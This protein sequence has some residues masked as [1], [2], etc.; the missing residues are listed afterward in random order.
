LGPCPTQWLRRLAD[1]RVGEALAS[2]YRRAGGGFPPLRKEHRRLAR[3]PQITPAPNRGTR[4]PALSAENG[5]HAPR[6]AH[7]S[8]GKSSSLNSNAGR[9]PLRTLAASR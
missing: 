1:A 7:S 4:T 9:R 8:S 6:L 3:L 5:S 2:R